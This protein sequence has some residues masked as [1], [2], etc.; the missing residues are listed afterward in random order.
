[1]LPV[2]Y[3]GGGRWGGESVGAKRECE[4]LGVNPCEYVD[5]SLETHT[6]LDAIL[7]YLRIHSMRDGGR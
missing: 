7:T 6:N 4:G 2:A 5:H 3:G 1:M